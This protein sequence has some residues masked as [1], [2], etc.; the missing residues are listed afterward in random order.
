MSRTSSTTGTR[1]SRSGARRR[2]ASI[3]AQ[4]SCREA[5]LRELLD[6]DAIR[7]PSVSEARWSSA[8]A[9]GGFTARHAAFDRDLSREEIAE[10]SD[11]K[12]GAAGWIPGAAQGQAR[13]RIAG[14]SED[15]AAE[16]VARFRDA[17]GVVP[18]RGLPRAL[19]EPVGGRALLD[20]ASR[21]RADA[22]ALPARAAAARLGLGVSPVRDTLSRLA[23]SDWVIEGELLPGGKTREWC[24]A[25]VLRTI[26]RRSLARLRREVEPVEQAALGRFLLEWQGVRRP[27]TGVDALLT[28]ISSSRECPSPAS[29]LEA[30]VLPARIENIVPAISHMLC[31]AGEI[32][33]AGIESLGPNDGRIALYL[34]DRLR[35]LA[36]PPRAEGSSRRRSGGCSRAEGP[37]SWIPCRRPG[38][39]RRIC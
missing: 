27:R 16:D 4:L 10:R 18:P 1:P 36:P 8:R 20:P 39:F 6:P 38:L 23:A 31:A 30:E 28:T 17:L 9:L 32:V 24:D 29:A 34:T 12:D 3:P 25:E 2:S 26:K 35:L 37:C 33:W 14:R 7:R 5:E 11:R 15:F 21:V 13:D 22:R 19:L